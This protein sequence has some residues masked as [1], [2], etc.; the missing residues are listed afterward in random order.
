MLS[1]KE[2]EANEA[3]QQEMKDHFWKRTCDHIYSVRTLM[4]KVTPSFPEIKKAL[5]Q[6]VKDHDVLKFGEEELVP[7]IWL[8]WMHKCKKDKVPFE[9][10]EGIEQQV[11]AATKHHILNSRHHPEYWA[12]E[13]PISPKDRDKALKPISA[14]KMDD[15]SIIEMV[16]D[17]KA[18]GL[19][20]GNPAR[21]W[22]DKVNGPRFI[23][24]D[25]QK[26]LIEKVLK[27][28][29]E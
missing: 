25:E 27:I 8:S 13:A 21:E 10:P 15:V 24:S 5:K 11:N 26:E 18:M 17:W 3:K 4:N 6:R 7:Y 9:Y 23:F 28:F 19:E 14:I 22:Y 20:L 16:C 12:G 1:F 2:F 29:G